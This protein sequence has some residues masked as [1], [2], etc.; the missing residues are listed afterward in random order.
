MDAFHNGVAVA[1]SK[2]AVAVESVKTRA[3]AQT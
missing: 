1:Q 2:F 3:G